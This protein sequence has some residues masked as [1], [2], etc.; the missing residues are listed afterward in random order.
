[1]KKKTSAIPVEKALPSQKVA[2]PQQKKKTLF[3]N[4]DDDFSFPSKK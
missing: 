1:M 3:D 2:Q 4:E